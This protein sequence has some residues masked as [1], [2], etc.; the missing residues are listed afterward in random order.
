MNQSVQLFKKVI[1]AVE[2]KRLIKIFFR[3]CEAGAESVFGNLSFS[4]VAALRSN[5]KGRMLWGYICVEVLKLTFLAYVA[6]DK[7][8]I[9][10]RIASAFW[11]SAVN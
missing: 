2:E 1:A 11:N 5:K 7:I 3:A 8:K 9:F 4:A 6:D 10:S